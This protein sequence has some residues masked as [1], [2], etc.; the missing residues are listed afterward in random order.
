MKKKGKSSALFTVIVLVTLF[1]A[2]SGFKG[3]VVGGWEV[4]SF[5]DVIKKVLIYKVEFLY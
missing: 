2:F 5:N 3:F 1:L 4:K